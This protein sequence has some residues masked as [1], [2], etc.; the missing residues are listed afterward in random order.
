MAFTQI[1]LVM[2][3]ILTVA[4][5]AT[6]VI[7]LLQ[8]ASTRVPE[9]PRMVALQASRPAAELPKPAPPSPKVEPTIIKVSG[10]VLDPAGKPVR[11]SRLWLAFQGI[12][13]TWSTRVP[14]VRAT[15]GPDGRFAFAVSDADP[16]VSRALRM[17]SGWPG[18]FGDI[19]VIASSEGFGP[20]WTGL[21]DIKGEIELRLVPD[22]IPIEGRLLT[23]EGRPIAG[24]TVKTQRVEDP[25]TSQKRFR[26]PLRL[27]PIRD[28]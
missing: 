6:G 28:D 23:L 17:T 14:E 24:I 1:K 5:G 19:Q 26:H 8:A 10:R 18:G 4:V 21:A 15:T 22:D 7:A 9:S 3:Y 2:A 25:S 27:L 16:E 11:G 12:D 13:W 20:A